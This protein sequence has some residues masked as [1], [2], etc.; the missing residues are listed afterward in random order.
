MEIDENWPTQ[1]AELLR[2][3][4]HSE[5]EVEKIVAHVRQYDLRTQHD[6]IMDSIG[7]GDIDLAEIVDEALKD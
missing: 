7:S 6:S 3:R 2:E 5:T 4:G 1:L